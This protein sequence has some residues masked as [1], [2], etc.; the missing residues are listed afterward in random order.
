MSLDTFDEKGRSNIKISSLISFLNFQDS[1]NSTSDIE[2][3]YANYPGKRYFYVDDVTNN[4]TVR[5]QSQP[6]I[7]T[8]KSN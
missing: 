8:F 2:R 3:T 5:R 4:V 6:S 7:F 1:S